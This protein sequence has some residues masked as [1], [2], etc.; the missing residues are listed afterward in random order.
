V[1]S[2]SSRARSVL[3]TTSKLTGKKIINLKKTSDDAYSV[4][5]YYGMHQEKKDTFSK[6]INKQREKSE[7]IFSNKTS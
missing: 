7:D 1:K 4:Q 6:P 3:S 5:D 2:G